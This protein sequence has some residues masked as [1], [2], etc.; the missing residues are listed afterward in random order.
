MKNI[1]KVGLI[2]NIVK[3]GLILALLVIFISSILNIYEKRYKIYG[4]TI[5]KLN[6]ER[7]YEDKK[8]YIPKEDIYWAKEILNGG[9][10]LHFRHAERDKWIEVKMYDSLES[11]LHNNGIDESRYAE[12]D[13]L[14]DAV[15]LNERGKVQA[16]VMGE[17]IKNIGLKINHIVS[18]VSCRARQTATLAFGE[19][20]SL[21]RILVHPG[22]YNEKKEDRIKKL[23]KFYLSLPQNKNGNVIVSSHNSVIIPEIFE[24]GK[25]LSDNLSLEEGGF[26]I[27]SIKNNKLYFEHEFHYF[28][29]FV[30]I[31]YER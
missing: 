8:Y 30:R 28:T 9:Y 2:K 29:N 16:R 19:Y 26:Y 17:H 7:P 11:D 31:F 1:V 18:S 12:N 25:N 23:K 27:I 10:I 15:C 4:T 24:N 20:D 6:L 3:V 13:Y 21:H 14:K 22:P 5:K